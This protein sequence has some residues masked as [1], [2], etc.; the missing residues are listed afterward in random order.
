MGGRRFEDDE[1]RITRANINNGVEIA[2]TLRK[3][4]IPTMEDV[5]K[6]IKQATE[7]N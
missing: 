6:R 7:E 1:L 2:G 5:R 4:R 3:L